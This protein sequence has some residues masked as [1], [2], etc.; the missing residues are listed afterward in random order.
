MNRHF[1]DST[2]NTSTLKRKK[3]SLRMEKLKIEEQKIFSE[4][5]NFMKKT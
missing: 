5:D 1:M 4:R 3:I 2:I